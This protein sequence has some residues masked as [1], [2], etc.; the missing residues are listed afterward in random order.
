MKEESLRSLKIENARSILELRRDYP[1]M[2]DEFLTALIAHD[3]DKLIP[4]IAE[5]QL[6]AVRTMDAEPPPDD[7][8]A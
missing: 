1:D 7:E 6:V 2:P 5:R 3:Q 8:A 4:R